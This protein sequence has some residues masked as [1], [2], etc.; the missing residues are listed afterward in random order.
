MSE[1]LDIHTAAFFALLEYR[2]SP[3]H[4]KEMVTMYHK[5]VSVTAKSLN[6]PKELKIFPMVPLS[7][8]TQQPIVDSL[9]P[10][11]VIT[12]TPRAEWQQ[13]SSLCMLGT[14]DPEG[15]KTIVRSSYL[16]LRVE[17]PAFCFLTQN[18][19]PLPWLGDS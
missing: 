4:T 17:T 15:W 19:H 14:A 2:I 6:S 12:L 16:F 8:E 18:F 5:S 3:F 7:N 9:H 11:W 1:H 10:L 13:T